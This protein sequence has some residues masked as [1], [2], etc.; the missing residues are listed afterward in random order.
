MRTKEPSNDPGE[1]RER[2][3]IQVAKFKSTIQLQRKEGRKEK[4]KCPRKEERRK[5]GRKKEVEEG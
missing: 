5:N 3:R 4:K 2:E 1:L